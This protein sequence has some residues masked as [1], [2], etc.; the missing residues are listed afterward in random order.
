[1]STQKI[2]KLIIS[3]THGTFAVLIDEQDISLFN[4]GKWCLSKYSNKNGIDYWYLANCNG[5]FH[6]QIFNIKDRKFLVDHIDHNTLNNVR[7]NLRIVTKSQNQAN[8]IR[9]N[10]KPGFVKS[11]IYKGVQKSTPNSFRVRIRV[12]SKEIYLGSFKCEIEAAKAYN[13]AARNH[14]GEYALLNEVPK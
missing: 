11:S 4:S 7:S 6:R 8:Q 12:D 5:L 9:I 13:E 3:K 2:E 1:M 10:E 14:F